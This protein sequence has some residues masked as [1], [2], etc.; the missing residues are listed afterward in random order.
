MNM[1]FGATKEYL[2]LMRKSY[3]QAKRKRHKSIIDEFCRVTGYERKYAIKLLSGNRKHKKRKGRKA[4]YGAEVRS[5]LIAVWRETGCMCSTYLAADMPYW[6]EDYEKH[7]ALITSHKVRS[8]LLS[9]SPSTMDR[10]LR[11]VERIKTGSLPRKRRNSAEYLLKQAIPCKSGEETM[12]ALVRPGDIQTDTFALGGGD[13]SGNFFWILDGT[14]RK[15]QWTWLSPTWNN[16][17][18]ATV[19]ALR[20]ILKNL[21]FVIYSMHH[22]NGSEI[23]NYHLAKNFPHL[24]PHAVLSRSRPRKCNDN[25]H[26][27]QKNR[28]VGRELF[29]ERRI[30]CRDLEEDLKRLCDEWS[31]FCNFFRPSKMLVSKEKRPDG[32]GFTRKYD[33]PSTP[34]KRI[35]NESSIP[36]KQKQKL[37]EAKAKVSGIDLRYRIVKRLK[38]ILRKQEEY[39]IAQ[40]RKASII[41]GVDASGSSLRDAP[42]GTPSAFDTSILQGA[43]TLGP[44]PISKK[45]SNLESVRILTNNNQRNSNKS[46]FST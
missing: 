26:V 28:S 2:G 14:D 10:L 41:R 30:D 7:V 21:P 12:A 25:A 5:A 46:V 15:T 31:F 43:I 44:K 18:V 42:S 9:M 36:Q 33:R 35:L 27:E 20:H 17:E 24:C 1:S 39:N 38:R 37:I 45:K 23:I 22:D 13:A 34:F 32:K 4:S 16:G 40:A 3:D 11:G 6:V 8:Q 19:K 29:G